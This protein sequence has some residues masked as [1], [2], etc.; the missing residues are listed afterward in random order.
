[1]GVK[2]INPRLADQEGAIKQIEE[3]AKKYKF[4]DGVI[5]TT[6]NK[7]F[8]EVIRGFDA[9][10]F[11]LFA[12]TLFTIDKKTNRITGITD[13]FV[14]LNQAFASKNIGTYIDEL[15]TANKEIENQIKAQKILT[16]AEYSLLAIQ[17]ILQDKTLTASIAEQGALAISVAERKELNDELR[18]S[19]V[20]KQQEAETKVGNSITE[21][22][23][24]IKAYEKLAAAGV[25]QEVINEILKDKANAQ[26]I[27]RSPEKIADQYGTLI[28]KTKSYLDLLK[29]IEEQTKT[30]EQ[31]TQEALDLNVSSLDLQAKTLQNAFDIANFDLKA[32]IK[33]SE[34]AIEDINDLIKEEQDKIDAINLVLKYDPAIGQNLLDDLQEKISD[35]QRSM[36]INFDRPIQV[37][38]DR[39]AILSNDLTLMDK[40]AEAIN[41]KY[42]KQEEALSKI[43]QLN[44]DIAAQEKNR[45]SLADALSQ[46]DISAAAQMANEMRSTAAEA[47]NRRSGDFIA[48]ARKFEIDNL[49][50]ASGMTKEQIQAEQFKI[51]QQTF[52]LEQQRKI[53]QAEILKLEDQVYNITELREA[54]LLQIRDIEAVI[55]GIKSGELAKEQEI[56]DRLQK[57]L[58]KEQEILDGALAKIELQK[59]KWDEVQLKLDAY[60][61]AL[62]KS[63]NELKSML[64]LIN[65][66]AK[67]MATIPTTPTQKASPFVVTTPPTSKTTLTPAEVAAATKKANDAADASDAAT[68]KAEEEFAAQ[69]AAQAKAD[70]EA[71]AATAALKKAMDD[72][73]KAIA[74]AAKKGDPASKDYMAAQKAEEA[75]LAAVAKQNL[76]YAARAAGYANRGVQANYASGGMVKPK[77]FAVGGSARGTDIIPAMLTPGEFVMSKYAVK[78]YGVDKMKAIN[79]GSYEG[80]KVYN[81]NLNVNVKS[82]ANPD[83]IARVVM[84]QIRQVDSQRIRTQRG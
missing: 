69:V 65:E 35:A 13:E 67:A 51:E 50:S 31:K 37:L 49:R 66:I 39:S 12:K 34:D 53:V 84:T 71:A 30:F 54:K 3:A 20:L 22:N 10:Q 19:I 14:F 68:K 17:T 18:K 73:K 44:S 70:A 27:A 16:D 64:D 11:E 52:A 25:K 74:D 77:Y 78:S 62:E 47:A 55:D 59:L 1:M 33:L 42:D 28:A 57:R 21:L 2:S 36:D 83:D 45:I 72:A 61:L 4:G 81:Y 24:Q 38:A 23:Y 80:E 9:T 46:G 56:L 79:S 6:L 8:M 76:Q 48:E 41:E 82:D 58:E 7:E 43:S 63:K 26:V 29:L 15:K 5:G 40:A 75:R 60:K 32:K